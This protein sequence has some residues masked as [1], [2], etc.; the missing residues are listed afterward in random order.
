MMI[1]IQKQA[2]TVR[3][4]V[5]NGMTKLRE[6]LNGSLIGLQIC[7]VPENVLS[8]EGAVSPDYLSVSEPTAGTF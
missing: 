2:F 1:N 4:L 5:Q 3:S 6:R 8:L 7:F